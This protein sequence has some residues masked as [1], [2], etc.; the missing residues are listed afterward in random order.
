MMSNKISLV[1]FG[2]AIGA[3]AAMLGLHPALLSSTAAT[4]AVSDTY[5]S[6]NLFG[7][8]FD[9]VRSDY[10]EKPDESKLVESA[11]NGMLSS[12]DPH[13]NTRRVRWLG[14]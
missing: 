7:D 2:A 8:V 12:L 10:V 1:L 14:H 13:S 6:L 11:I 5:K 4:A 3:S 9:R